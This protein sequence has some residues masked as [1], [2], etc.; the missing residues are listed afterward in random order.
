ME[1]WVHGRGRDPLSENDAHFGVHNEMLYARK[2]KPIQGAQWTGVV[3]SIAM[4]MLASGKVDAVICVHRYTGVHADAKGS[5]QRRS[6][7]EWVGGQQ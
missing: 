1:P 5:R 4:A 7:A 6:P 3:T 2:L